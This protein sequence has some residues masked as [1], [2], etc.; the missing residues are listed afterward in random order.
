MDQQWQENGIPIQSIG[1]LR[2]LLDGFEK[3][4]SGAF[5][6]PAEAGG[7]NEVEC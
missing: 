2:T 5:T 7:V 6:P 4:T 3:R 1:P